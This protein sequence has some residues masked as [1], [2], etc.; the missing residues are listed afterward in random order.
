MELPIYQVDAFAGNV[1]GGNPAAVCPLNEPLDARLMQAIAMENNLSET[2]FFHPEGQNFRL[3]WFTPV[4]EIDL[5]GHATLASAWVLFEEL[6]YDRP[7]IRFE[8]QSGSLIVSRDIETGL[9]RMDFPA[10]TPK[11]TTPPR[12]LL[13]GLRGPEPLEVLATRDWLVVYKNEEDVLRLNPDMEALKAL[14][15]LG[16]II[17]AKGGPLSNADFV[18]R[19]FVPGEGIPEDPVTGSAHSTLIPYWSPRLGKQ[20]MR[21]VQLSKRRGELFCEHNGERVAI[22]GRAVLYMRGSIYL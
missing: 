12:A 6:G 19:F 5:C 18:S 13:D 15:R 1:F 2:A 20:A 16:V 21:A 7:E 8:T 4:S 14:D 22:S 3:R 11:P 9:L 10:W 17:T